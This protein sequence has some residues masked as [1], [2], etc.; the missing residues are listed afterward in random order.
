MNLL[1]DDAAAGTSEELQFSLTPRRDWGGRG[2]L[3]CHLLPA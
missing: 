1:R 2:L 3:G